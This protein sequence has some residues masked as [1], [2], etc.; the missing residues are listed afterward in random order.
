[1]TGL[2]DTSVI[3][4]D[5][6]KKSPLLIL[7]FNNCPFSKGEKNILRESS[8]EIFHDYVIEMIGIGAAIEN[9][10]LAAHVSGLGGVCLRDIC[11]YSEEIKKR[12]GIPHDLI[13]AIA[14]GH[15]TN[16]SGKR[17]LKRELTKV[18]T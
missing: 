9:I 7:V 10:L 12:Y 1:M 15:P 13:C 3:S 18:I 14:I 2:V 5:I 8:L 17:E 4:L 6:I 11:V 16:I